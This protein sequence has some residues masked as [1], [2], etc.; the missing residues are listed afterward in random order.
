MYI[1]KEITLV[2]QELE[3]DKFC[4]TN[5]MWYPQAIFNVYII[6][7]LCSAPRHKRRSPFRLW[8]PQNKVKSYKYYNVARW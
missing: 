6:C 5:A 4:F 2:L 3:D 1:V 7:V 8:L